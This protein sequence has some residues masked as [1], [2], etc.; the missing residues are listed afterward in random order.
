LKH[1]HD[2]KEY[3]QQ[4]QSYNRTVVSKAKL[5]FKHEKICHPFTGRFGSSINKK[6]SFLG[7]KGEKAT[8][9]C[10]NTSRIP[11]IQY[12]KTSN[13][14]RNKNANGEG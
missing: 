8:S 9:K 4:T 14:K 6:G 2:K 3:P 13:C 7:R 11:I 12:T 1:G 5:P 10:T